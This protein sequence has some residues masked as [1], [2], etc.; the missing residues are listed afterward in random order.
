MMYDQTTNSLLLNGFMFLAS[1][2]VYV[3]LRAVFA[4][5][6]SAS[7]VFL[8]VRPTNLKQVRSIEFVNPLDPTST[9]KYFSSCI[10]I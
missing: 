10:I 1:H 2:K 5:E 6:S 8:F 7:L 9:G 3:A 4:T